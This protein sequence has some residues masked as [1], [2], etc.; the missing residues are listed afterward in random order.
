MQVIGH[1]QLRIKHVLNISIVCGIVIDSLNTF[2]CGFH[3]PTTM[4]S[5][6]THDHET[7]STNMEARLIEMEEQLKK[8]S[9]MMEALQQENK[10]LKWKN[11]AYSEGAAP[12]HNDQPDG[13]VLSA[14][15]TNPNQETDAARWIV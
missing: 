1:D 15:R 11:Q 4:H 5:Q 12:N 7:V 14:S 3:M 10:G 6:T 13:E 9:E 2:Q 8:L